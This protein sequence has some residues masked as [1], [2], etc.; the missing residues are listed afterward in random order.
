[1]T[2]FYNA[3]LAKDFLFAGV[4]NNCLATTGGGTAGCVMSLNITGGAPAV[5]AGTIALPAVGGPTGII[6]DNAS[7]N[8]QLSSV[9][10]ATKTG[11]T[12]VKATQAGLQ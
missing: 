9:Y 11:A 10:Y 1:V 12:L 2:E 7:S 4:T 3:N 6:V 8:A 5:T